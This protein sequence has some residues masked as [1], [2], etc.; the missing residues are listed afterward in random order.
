[1]TVS[2]FPIQLTWA[3]L[4]LHSCAPL[5]RWLLESCLVV[6][7]ALCSRD[8]SYVVEHRMIGNVPVPIF[9]MWMRNEVYYPGWYVCC[10]TFRHWMSISLYWILMAAMLHLMSAM[11]YIDAQFLEFG[12]IDES[13]CDVTEPLVA[14]APLAFLVSCLCLQWHGP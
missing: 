6:W 8:L 12:D 4:H 2:S 13:S 10:L 7:T 11:R 3:F 14:L 1:M 5:Q 9:S